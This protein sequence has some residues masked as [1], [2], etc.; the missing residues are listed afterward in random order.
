MNNGQLQPLRRRGKVGVVEDD[1]RGL[2]TELEAHA[3]QLLAADRSDAPPDRSRS[4]EGDL[5]DTVMPDEVLADLAAGGDDA[6]HTLWDAGFNKHLGHQHRVERRLGRRLQHDGAT[7]NERRRKLRHR[8]ELRHV[9]GRDR[10]DH[11]DRLATNDDIAAEHAGARVLPL[12]RGSDL[13]HGI[14]DEERRR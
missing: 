11:T 1:R 2:P 4:G 8:R 14:Q 13:K 12:V 10:T 5:I 9:P 3:L 7:R 6:D